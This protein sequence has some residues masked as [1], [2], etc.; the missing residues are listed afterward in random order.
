MCGLARPQPVGPCL[1]TRLLAVRAVPRLR[2]SPSWCSAH[3]T[4]SERALQACTRLEADARGLGA[5]GLAERWQAASR[6]SVHLSTGLWA[7]LS[8]PPLAHNLRVLAAG[9]TAAVVN[10]GWLVQAPAALAFLSIGGVVGLSL[11][12]WYAPRCCGLHQL[13]IPKTRHRHPG[14]SLCIPARVL[15]WSGSKVGGVQS[16]V[17][18]T[19]CCAT[20]VGVFLDLDEP[21]C[22]ALNAVCVCLYA[23]SL[24]TVI[25]LRGLLNNLLLPRAAWAPA[26]LLHGAAFC[27]NAVIKQLCQGLQWQAHTACEATRNTSRAAHGRR[28]RAQGRSGGGGGGHCSGSGGAA[29]QS[30]RGAEGSGQCGHARLGRL[31]L[32]AGAAGRGHAVPGA[33]LGPCLAARPVQG[34]LPCVPA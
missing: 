5:L 19:L 13:S 8:V 29:C 26:W 27:H 9:Q 20:L 3:P 24:F 17:T 23:A 11:L 6:T 21:E 33:L 2:C 34:L 32:R 28:R 12:F 14:V 31:E 30:W 15:C 7:A 18:Y 10:Q 4:V 25:A 1:P 22:A 16:L